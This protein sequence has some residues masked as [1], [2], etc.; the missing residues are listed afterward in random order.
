MIGP[1]PG[2]SAEEFDYSPCRPMARRP[3][4]ETLPGPEAVWFRMLAPSPGAARRSL[5]GRQA[6]WR[7]ERHFAHRS[8]DPN[9]FGFGIG[10]TLPV[11][12]AAE[13]IALAWD[14]YAF[15]LANSPA[16]D[17][18]ERTV[19][20]WVLEALNFPLSAVSFGTS[21][22]ACGLAC[23]TA[24]WRTLLASKGWDFD[25]DGLRRR[26][27]DISSCRRRVDTQQ[28]APVHA[29]GGSRFSFAILAMSRILALRPPFSTKKRPAV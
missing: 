15:P 5:T 11:T 19:V 17:G 6:A 14:Q 28:E 4:R 20:K 27:T 13:R 25:A 7:R 22:S 26:L 21:A 18:I 23:L 24:A 3:S 29:A 16:A 12:A 2:R 9:Y 8:D 1:E 10:A